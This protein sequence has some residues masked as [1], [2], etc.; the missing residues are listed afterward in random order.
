MK[1]VISMILGLCMLLSVSVFAVS[2]EVAVPE[3]KDGAVIEFENYAGEENADL[4]VFENL[5][6]GKK[7]YGVAIT[8]DYTNEDGNGLSG[9]GALSLAERAEATSM[10]F[11]VPVSVTEPGWYDVE[12]Y[13]TDGGL[14][15]E[16]L[17]NYTVSLGDNAFTVAGNTTLYFQPAKTNVTGD[18]TDLYYYPIRCYKGRIYVAED[19]ENMVISATP[20]TNGTSSGTGIKLIIDS[21]TF[22][23]YEIAT[24]SQEKEAVVE[25]EDCIPDIR[26]TFQ[27]GK[28]NSAGFLAEPLASGGAVMNM[29]ER[30]GIQAMEF[31]IPIKIADDGFYVLNLVANTSN[32]GDTSVLYIKNGE[33]EWVNNW[34]HSGYAGKQLLYFGIE[35]SHFYYGIYDP[36][37]VKYLTAGEYMLT[38]SAVGITNNPNAT[39]FIADCLKVSPAKTDIPAGGKRLEL[40]DFGAYMS[41]RLSS[42]HTNSE[43]GET[44]LADLGG[45]TTGLETVLNFAESGYYNVIFH[46]SPYRN[47]GLSKVNFYLDGNLLMDNNDAIYGVSNEYDFEQ[48]LPAW[49]FTKEYV[50]I[51]AGTYIL[52]MEAIERDPENPANLCAYAADYLDFVKT[53][54]PEVSMAE[55]ITLEMEDYADD[56]RYTYGEGTNIVTITSAPLASGGKVL[57]MAEKT[58]ITALEFD[59]PI[60]VAE[61]GWYNVNLIASTSDTQ[62]TSVLSIKNG[63][64]EWVSNWKNSGYAGQETLYFGTEDDGHYKY[65]GVHNH[66]LARYIEAGE[67]NLTASAVAITNN[68]N[69]TKF[70]ADCLQVT[71]LKMEVSGA[72]RIELE[73]MQNLFEPWKPSIGVA[74]GDAAVSALWAY[75]GSDVKAELPL[76]FLESGYYDI[77]FFGTPYL[78]NGLSKINISIDGNPVLD[79]DEVKGGEALQYDY[80]EFLPAYKFEKEFIYIEKGV[81]N[82]TIE[83]LMRDPDPEKNNECAFGMDAIEIAPVEDEAVVDTAEK[84]IEVTAYYGTPVSGEMI[85]VAYAGGKMVGIQSFNELDRTIFE[86]II[87]YE[88]NVTPDTVKVFVWEEYNNIHPIE[89]EKIITVK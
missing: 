50:Y 44:Y 36:K 16:Y 87:D 21:M 62:S 11:T 70:V 19:V 67:Y 35:D 51:E 69:A 83:A 27:E 66:Q 84:R 47:N 28:T 52:N 82:V 77:R 61:S 74:D 76:S 88:G 53:E 41:P 68:P 31:D 64:E 71:P 78:K 39:K 15:A 34:Q 33:E 72:T 24:A 6:E 25:M 22:N 13:G 32:A 59:I 42:V 85:A 86:A 10:T 81:H 1:K 26:Y 56:I 2:A 5:K 3:I 29:E 65:Y 38:A 37:T 54:L 80:K 89:K 8:S 12:W 73:D 48:Y 23:K 49:T 43:T 14:K 75:G 20:N 57:D 55:G 79:N 58:N 63:E 46:G 4:Y 18:N 60:V 9:G 7:P 40:E 17:S 30:A 45:V